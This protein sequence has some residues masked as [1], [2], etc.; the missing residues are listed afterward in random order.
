MEKEFSVFKFH[1]NSPL[2]LSRGRGDYDSSESIL[3]SDTII[4]ALMVAYKNIYQDDEKE[5]FETLII[6]S[7][8]PFFD[9][10]YFFPKP[11]LKMPA[12]ENEDSLSIAKKY[13]KI[14]W[15]SQSHFENV[16]N[17]TG[18]LW[19]ENDIVFNSSFISANADS[20]RKAQFWMNEIQQR[21]QI[22]NSGDDTKPY[23]IERIRFHE[24]G[25]LYFLIDGNTEAIQ[26]INSCMEWLGDQGIGTD[27]SVGNGQFNPSLEKMKLKLPA[28]DSGILLSLYC[29]N[30]EERND[31][32]LENAKYNIIKRGGYIA[33]AS[34]ESNITLQ[35]KSIFMFTEG[36][37][38]PQFLKRKGS[39]VD[40]N[41]DANIVKHPVWRD[42][43]SF[44]IPINL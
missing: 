41:P 36:S 1:F 8:F 44:F 17:N 22:P 38:F 3:H 4:A 39:I 26:K 13:K 43:R 33:S 28:S 14:N 23:Y 11:F 12:F 18:L 24:N 29:P 35:K 19:K 30:E 25:G 5:F 42:G 2:H 16:I 27:K 10:E 34:D 9:N 21:V 37:V 40:L 31:G 32:F 20:L 15:L 6:S 7:A